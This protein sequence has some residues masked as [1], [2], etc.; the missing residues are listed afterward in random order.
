MCELKQK[1]I[2]ACKDRGE[3]PVKVAESMMREYIN[4]DKPNYEKIIKYLNDKTGKNFRTTA[5]TRRFISARFTDGFTEADFIRVIDNQVNAWIGTDME[6]YLRP[7]T[8]FRPS[9][10]ESYLNKKQNKN[11]IF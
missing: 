6:Q 7:Q 3:D 5:A 2:A 8:L 1:F 11:L 10:F 9:N 4:K